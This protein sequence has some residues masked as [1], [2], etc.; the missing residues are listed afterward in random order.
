MRMVCILSDAVK[1]PLARLV[2][3]LVVLSLLFTL[4][5]SLWYVTVDLPNREITVPKNGGLVSCTQD[6]IYQG[7]TCAEGE[8]AYCIDQIDGREHGSSA[9]Q[10]CI[11]NYEAACE[12]AEKTCIK[13]CPI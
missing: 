10:N 8:M 6:C 7:V 11:R 4:A 13:S 9:Y 12:A 2:L 3:V 5:A 1:S